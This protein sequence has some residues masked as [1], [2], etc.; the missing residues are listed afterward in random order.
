VLEINEHINNTLTEFVTAIQNSAELAR[1]NYWIFS[2]QLGWK[3]RT[4]LCT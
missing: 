2:E 4:L 1:H 3:N